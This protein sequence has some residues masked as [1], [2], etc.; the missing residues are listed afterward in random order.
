VPTSAAAGLSLPEAVRLLQP[1]LRCRTGRCQ[2]C[3]QPV[4]L[5]QLV[6]FHRRE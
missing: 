3:R 2:T 5:G 6:L 4:E 1:I